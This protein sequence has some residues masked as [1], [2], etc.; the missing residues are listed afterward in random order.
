MNNIHSLLIDLDGTVY[1]K[2]CGIWEDM[3]LRIDTYMRTYLRVPSHEIQPLRDKLF[4]HYGS[5][6]RGLQ[7]VYSVDAS[8]YLD[9]IHDLPLHK[10]ISPDPT[11]RSALQSIPLPKWIFTNADHSH[12]TRV[13]RLVGIE[14]LF[15]GIIDVWKMDF[16]PKPDPI[17]YRRALALSGGHLPSQVLFADDTLKNLTP[18][19][20]MGFTTVWVGET[21]AH[22]SASI[23]LKNLAELPQHL[24]VPI[25]A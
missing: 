2:D 9:F 4:A 24:P 8:H 3:T 20:H 14:D 10:Y 1:P 17:V 22:P 19:R 18:A 12:A 21:Q 7:S 25:P 13:L 5:T 23:V 11:L 16:I 15:E 6:L